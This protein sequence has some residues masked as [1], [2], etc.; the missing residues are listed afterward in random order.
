M[1]GSAPV[2]KHYLAG[3]LV[4]DP[5]V[6]PRPWSSHRHPA[7]PVV[8]RARLEARFTGNGVV[9]PAKRRVCEERIGD[10]LG[11]IGT[12]EY[13]RSTP[14]L[15]GLQDV[16]YGHSGFRTSGRRLAFEA[17]FLATSEPI[18][19]S[20]RVLLIARRWSDEAG[21]RQQGVALPHQQG[22]PSTAGALVLADVRERRPG[23]RRPKC[24]FAV[25][26]ADVEEVIAD[27]LDD[28]APEVLLVSESVVSVTSAALSNS[29][30]A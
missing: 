14:L 16:L 18:D 3:L 28:S 2:S 17:G 20:G 29:S 5:C 12:C 10:V 15:G 4:S 24:G 1:L 8:P 11:D 19:E 25:L 6:R 23:L 30:R 22:V 27:V 26:L 9:A 13:N 21:P 7:D